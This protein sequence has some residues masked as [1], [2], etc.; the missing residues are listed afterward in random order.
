MNYLAHLHL[1]DSVGSHLAASLLAD[2]IRGRPDGRFTADVVTGIYLHRHID[3]EVDA[4]AQVKLAKQLFPVPLRRFAGIALDLYWDH[5]LAVHWHHYHPTA[6][7]TFIDQ[8]QQRILPFSSQSD[9]PVEYLHLQQRM[10]SQGWLQSYR[11]TGNIVYALQRISQRR[12]RFGPLAE[13]GEYL[14]KHYGTLNELFTELYPLMIDKVEKYTPPP[15]RPSPK[16][17]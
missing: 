17:D 9:L 1:A 6:L 15:N 11:E 3:R 5:F 14:D 12:P 10:W 16:T 2:F 13:C 4:T 8:A 7:N